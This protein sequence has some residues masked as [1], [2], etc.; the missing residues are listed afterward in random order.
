MIT[1]LLAM[2]V[3]VLFGFAIARGRHPAG[4]ADVVDRD[5]QRVSAELNAIF[6]RASKHR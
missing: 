3:I 6:G 2:A 4:S 1:F 5:A